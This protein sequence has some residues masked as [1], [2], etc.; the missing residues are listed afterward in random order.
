MLHPPPPKKLPPTLKDSTTNIATLMKA[1]CTHQQLKENLLLIGGV[2]SFRQLW[3]QT[4]VRGHPV[5]RIG[6]TEKEE[7]NKWLVS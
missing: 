2:L 3:Q 6:T 7:I 5:E 1:D 4:Q